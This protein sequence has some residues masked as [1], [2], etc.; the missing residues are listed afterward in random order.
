[1]TGDISE[2]RFH[3]RGDIVRVVVAHDVLALPGSAGRPGW[4]MGGFGES[5]TVEWLL[6]EGGLPGPKAR[7][8]ALADMLVRALAAH[9]GRDGGHGD[10]HQRARGP[11]ERCRACNTPGAP[12]PGYVPSVPRGPR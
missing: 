1:M 6:H 4:S 9:H 10:G 11:F 7:R 5:I 12:M 2:F 3:W 8:E